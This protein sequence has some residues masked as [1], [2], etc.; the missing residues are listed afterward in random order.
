MDIKT[1]HTSLY[2]IRDFKEDD[3]KFIMATFLKGLYHGDSW[4]SL[5]PPQVFMDNY[6]PALQ[7]LMASPKNT[8]HVA[9]LKDDPDIILGYSILG[10]NFNAIHWVFVKAAWRNGGIGRML[11]PKNPEVVTHLTTLGKSLMSKFQNTIFN[12]FHKTE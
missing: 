2:V 4:F 3:R 7:A 9:C 12:P 8:I 1:D 6:K 10:N 11:T 5:I